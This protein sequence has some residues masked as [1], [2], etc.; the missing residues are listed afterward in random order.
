MRDFQFLGSGPIQFDCCCFKSGHLIWGPWARLGSTDS[1]QYL[2]Q[3]KN[4]RFKDENSVFPGILRRSLI[5]AVIPVMHHGYTLGTQPEAEFSLSVVGPV[6]KSLLANAHDD[7]C[8]L[9]NVQV[10]ALF[11][12]MRLG[13][14][15]PETQAEFQ[16]EINQFVAEPD[17]GFCLHPR[18]QAD[19]FYDES[20]VS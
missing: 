8:R 12:D 14:F 20:E 17:R 3:C 1:I 6:P 18:D 4:I 19:G 7:L 10:T 15:H 11:V 9:M 2:A 16:R 5:K 13:F